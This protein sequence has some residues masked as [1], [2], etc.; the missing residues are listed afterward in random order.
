[1]LLDHCRSTRLDLIKEDHFELS[2]FVLVALEINELR[3]HLIPY[4]GDIRDIRYLEDFPVTGL[5][6]DTEKPIVPPG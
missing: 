4:K 5:K 1:M 3:C 6:R 2:F